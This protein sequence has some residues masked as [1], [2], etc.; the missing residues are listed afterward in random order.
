MSENFDDNLNNNESEKNKG[1]CYY[2]HPRGDKKE[3]ELFQCKYCKEWFCEKCTEPRKPMLAPFKITDIE[4]HI[5]WEK[6]GGHPCIPYLYHVIKKEE[7]LKIKMDHIYFG[8]K[9]HVE[10]R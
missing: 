1:T 10:R 5:E 8:K 9:L 6:K 3:K 7:D 4:E 2:C